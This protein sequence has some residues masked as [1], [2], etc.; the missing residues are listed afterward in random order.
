MHLRKG[1]TAK[2]L[3]KTENKNDLEI[4][5]GKYKVV[6]LQVFHLAMSFSMLLQM[7]NRPTMHDNIS[8]FNL[9]VHS[10]SVCAPTLFLALYL[11]RRRRSLLLW[12]CLMLRFSFKYIDMFQVENFKQ[13]IRNSISARVG[14]KRKKIKL[15]LTLEL[16]TGDA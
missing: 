14:G 5:C 3:V 16:D 11:R 1:E 6:R 7:T 2:N 10:S 8:R 15:C 9:F 12:L 13:K 4:N